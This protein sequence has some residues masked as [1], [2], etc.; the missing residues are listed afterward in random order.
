MKP[1]PLL[2]LLG[3]AGPVSPEVGAPDAAEPVDASEP[4]D[5]GVA[6]AGPRL[7]GEAPSEL[8]V[9]HAEDRMAARHLV[10]AYQGAARAR[11]DVTR[12]AI[13]ARRRA[14]EAREAALAGEDFRDVARRYSDDATAER[15]GFLGAFNR[16]EM[17]ARF[18][19]AAFALDVGEVSD[20][21][22]TPFG[23]HVILREPLQEVHLAQ[24]VV[25][26]A[27][28]R[29]SSATRTQEEAR[30]R[31]EEAAARLRAGEPAATVAR[32]LSDGPSAAWGGDLGSFQR[33]ELAAPFDDLAF[34]L[35]VGEVSDVV[36]SP[37]G[38]HVFVRVE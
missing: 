12:T 11:S 33:G 34:A 37:S 35:D 19:A 17:D 25:Q 16:G 15:G 9:V 30:A 1:L 2:L 20:V 36:E 14:R 6:S 31:V 10:V 38:F 13:E 22:E 28:L 32:A 5:S 29:R 23:Y 18:E 8:T 26:Y 27:G 3:C 21:V 7:P 24:V 4:A